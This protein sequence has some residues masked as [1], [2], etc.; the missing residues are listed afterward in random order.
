MHGRDAY[1]IMAGKPEGK[2]LFGRTTR[3]WV[4]NIGMDLKE[5]CRS[6][7]TEFILL[8]IWTSGVSL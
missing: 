3:R 4:N 8:R 7:L 6:V 1:N 5:I 2:R